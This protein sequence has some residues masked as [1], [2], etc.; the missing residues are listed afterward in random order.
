M[1]L[2]GFIV[3]WQSFILLRQLLQQTGMHILKNVVRQHRLQLLK[4]IFFGMKNER[5]VLKIH[6]SINNLGS[7]VATDD[8]YTKCAE[9]L[10][11]EK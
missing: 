10:E 9:R 4:T 2:Q 3:N 11:K 8:D 5:C 7:I 1:L 6:G